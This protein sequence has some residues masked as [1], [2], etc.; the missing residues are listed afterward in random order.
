MST[1]PARL[2]QVPT[3]VAGM[4]VGGVLLAAVGGVIGL[5]VGLHAYAPTAWFAVLEIG[6]PA[7]LVG[8][9]LGLLVGFLHESSRRTR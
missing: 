8:G 3:P 1:L 6:V 5:I 7:G 2:R 9:L 4:A